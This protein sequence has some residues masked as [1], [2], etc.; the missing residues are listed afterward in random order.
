MEFVLA[1]VADL[2]ETQ[3]RLLLFAQAL[4]VKQDPV[5]VPA[6]HDSDV[7]EAAATVAATLETSRAGIIYQHQAASIP[8]QRLAEELTRAFGALG[9][10]AGANAARLEGDGATALRRLEGIARNAGSALADPADPDRSWIALAKR[11]MAQG[12][13][14]AAPEPDRTTPD[15]EPRIILP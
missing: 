15:D 3:Y 4:V 12:T 11:M 7:A 5:I 14:D 9:Q 6:L 8:A 10:E 2:T 1:H 13:G